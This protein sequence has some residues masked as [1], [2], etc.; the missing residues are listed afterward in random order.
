MQASDQEGRIHELTT[1]ITHENDAEKL[2]V[3]ARELSISLDDRLEQLKK[4][5]QVDPTAQSKEAGSRSL[6]F[7]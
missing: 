4:K 1:T 2:V 7:F 5:D 6:N 3:L